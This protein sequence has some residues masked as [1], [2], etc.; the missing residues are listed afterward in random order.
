[1]KERPEKELKKD[2]PDEIREED[3]PD[4]DVDLDGLLAQ[5]EPEPKDASEEGHEEE[6]NDQE[7]QSTD[8]VTI[9]EED[10]IGIPL[11]DD[12]LWDDDSGLDEI[13]LFED[14]L[15]QIEGEEGQDDA[16]ETIPSEQSEDLVEDSLDTDL[17]GQIVDKDVEN[18][19]TPSADPDNGNEAQEG[20]AAVHDPQDESL[21]EHSKN[22]LAWFVTGI[23]GLLILAGVFALHRLY[24]AP[25][26]VQ[27]R[28]NTNQISSPALIKKT[29]APEQVSKPRYPK[30]KKNQVSGK[31]EATNHY[32]SGGQWEVMALAPFLIPA[33]Q[34]GELVFF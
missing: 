18:E 24:T 30:E 4:E 28:T 2:A 22:W 15:D 16:E 11:N 5:D 34:A 14:E 23:S 10:E 19:S 17:A 3:L 31:A 7:D 25:Y 13:P 9:D 21:A 32:Q 20:T 6:S 1:L 12:E 8:S 33:Y 27:E 29:N 26:P